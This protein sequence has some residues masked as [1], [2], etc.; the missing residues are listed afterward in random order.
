[1]SI[2]DKRVA[3]KPYEYPHLLSYMNAIRGTLW[4]IDEFKE[5]LDRDVNEYHNVLSE[6]EK[7]IMKRSLLAISQIEVNVK[8][9]WGKVGDNLPKPEI[10]MVGYTFAMNE[11]IHQEALTM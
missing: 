7:N 5:R 11:V 8:T 4:F 6:A 10:Y 1:M 3:V 9:F 2:F